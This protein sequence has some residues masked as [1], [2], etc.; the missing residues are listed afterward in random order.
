MSWEA[1]SGLVRTG[2]VHEARRQ[3]SQTQLAPSLVWSIFLFLQKS[4]GK[5]SGLRKSRSRQCL[6]N[7]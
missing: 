7:A 5:R 6:H 2:N 1:L 4:P 3:I